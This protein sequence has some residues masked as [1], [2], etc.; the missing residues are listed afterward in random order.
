MSELDREC[1]KE[2]LEIGRGWVDAY[3]VHM[4]Q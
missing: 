1:L 4:R 2:S 3:V